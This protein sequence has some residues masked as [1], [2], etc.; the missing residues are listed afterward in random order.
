MNIFLKWI[1]SPLLLRIL[2]NRNTAFRA[3]HQAEHD[4]IDSKYTHK[5]VEAGGVHW[6]YVEMGKT[7]GPMVLLLHGLPESWY[8]WHKVLPLLDSSFHYIVP[9]MKGYGR[10]TSSDINYN[11]HHVADQTFS[12]MDTLSTPKFYIVGHDWGALISSVMVT[13][14]PERFLGNIRIEADLKYTPSQSLDKLY[15]QKPQWKIFQ[16]TV[17]AVLFLSDAEKVIDV[18]YPSRMLMKLEPIDR[19]YFIFEFSRPEVAKAIANYFKFGNWDLEAA[20]TKIANNT[21]GFPVLQLQADSDPAQLKENFSDTERLFPNVK[22]E[23]VINAS[24]FDNLD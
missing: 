14:H 3:K 5:Y 15:A 6:H 23:W 17:R 9:D 20:V 12:L 18:V 19:N 10:S 8:S 24:H 21:F 1:Y 13:D 7:N 4:A 2:S 16:D 22:L 11:W